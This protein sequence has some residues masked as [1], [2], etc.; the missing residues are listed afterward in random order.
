VLREVAGTLARDTSRCDLPGRF[1]R[2]EFIVL[3]THSGAVEA[4]CIAE[5]LRARISELVISADPGTA[6]PPANVTVSI[7]IATVTGT[8]SDL[9]DLLAAADVA[10]YWAECAGYN[11]VRL[12]DR[13]PAR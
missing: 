9:T 5:L 3:L 10:L 7:G 8:I 1:G 6:G 11:N 4:L 2:D 13:P 12:A